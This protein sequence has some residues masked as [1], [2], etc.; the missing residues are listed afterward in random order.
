[1]EALMARIAP[2]F[3]RGTP[4]ITVE[5]KPTTLPIVEIFKDGRG[6]LTC[7][8]AAAVMFSLMSGYFVVSWSPMLLSV[9]GIK[10]SQAVIAGSMLQVG[11]VIGALIWGRLADH[12]WPPAVLAGAAMLSVVCYSLVGH[13]T[14]SFALLI[15][16]LF[17]GGMGM[18]VQNT[19]NS[20][21][22]SLYPT[23]MRGTALGLIFAVA[24]NGSIAGPLIG[25]ALLAAG[26]TT[27]KLYY[28]PAASLLVAI[29]C[30]VLV[31]ILPQPRRIISGSQ[32][33]G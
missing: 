22:S 18:G 33:A 24:R 5:A 21:I 14:S 28:V 25:G 32:A 2:S 12:V 20:L 23:A 7:L 4:W 27:S 13:A 11:A 8:L 30:M 31:S 6:A 29:V 9:V 19:Y 1:V 3:P 17:V 16:V 10:L 26:W 15:C